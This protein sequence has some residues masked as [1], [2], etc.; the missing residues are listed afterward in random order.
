MTQGKNPGLKAGGGKKG[1][2]KRTIDPLSRKEWYDFRAPIPFSSKSFGKTLVTKSS[3]NRIASDEIKGR[4]VESTLADLKDN[5]G[6]KS[7]R[8]VKLVIDEVDGRNAKT[9][10]YGLDITRDRLCSMIRKWQ[11]LIEARV[12]CKTNDGY[13]VRVFTLAFTKKVSGKQSSTSTSYAKHSQVRAIRRK[14]NTFITNEAAKLGIAEFSK[15]LIGEDYTKKIEKET[16]NIF[17][18]QNI[19]IRKVKV[20]KR[21]KLDATKIAEL[22]SHEKKGEKATGRDGAPEEQDAKNLMA[23]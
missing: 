14:I 17:P 5:S 20:L 10:F 11:T 15:N 7:W 9:S 19:T 23:E 4:V 18:L 8:K 3:G 12:D 16:K 21:P 13:I 6:D 22:Y 1:A 2:K